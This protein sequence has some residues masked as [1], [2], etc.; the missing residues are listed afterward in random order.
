MREYGTVTG[1]L[2]LATVISEPLSGTVH[3]RG[4]DGADFTTAASGPRGV[5]SVRVPT[6]VY[7]VRGRSPHF[8]A[9][10]LDCLGESAVTVAT[11]FT[12]HVTVVC[13]GF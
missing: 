4:A 2:E 13:Q 3:L 8:Q 5:F 6:G 11:N 10:T 1:T 12:T 9:G 7:T